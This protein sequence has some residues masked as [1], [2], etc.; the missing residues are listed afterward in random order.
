MKILLSDCNEYRAVISKRNLIL[1]VLDCDEIVPI[2][3]AKI[4]DE[5]RIKI[6]Q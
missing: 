5:R 4:E 3:M 6:C 2:S 1:Y